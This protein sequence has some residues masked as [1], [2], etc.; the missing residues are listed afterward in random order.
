MSSGSKNNLA[1][2]KYDDFAKYVLDVAEYFISQGIP[3]TELSPINEPQWDWNDG[4][5]GC[6]Y[7]IDEAV[8]V[9]RLFALAIKE[10]G[11]DVKI[12]ALESGQVGDHAVECLEKL[13]ADED[14]RS[15]LGT[16]A[17][18]SYWTDGDVARK[19]AFGKY[20]DKK[21]P[22]LET[23]MSEWCELPCEHE[24]DDITAK[25]SK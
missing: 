6:H 2:D 21:Y 18:H 25:D 13:Y 8:E 11:M 10:R 17:Y 4:Q 1:A 20:I 14:I 9:I 12:S 3:V 22:L 16:Y 23:E 15:V 19:A 7:E 24:I 5:E